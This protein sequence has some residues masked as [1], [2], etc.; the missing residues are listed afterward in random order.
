MLN[1]LLKQKDY[2]SILTMNDGSEAT[3]QSWGKRRKELFA[4]LEE[5]SYGKTPDIPVKVWGEVTD[6]DPN[7][8]AGKVLDEKIT[9][10]METEYGVFSFPIELFVPKNTAKPLYFCTL[11]SAVF[12]TNISPWRRLPTQAMPLR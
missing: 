9:V 8:Y 10:Y 12:P 7:A 6:S 4:L 5:Y 3:A 11:H 2:L 1:K